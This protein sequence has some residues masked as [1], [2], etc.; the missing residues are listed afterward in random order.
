MA[1]NYAVSLTPVFFLL[2]LTFGIA[3]ENQCKFNCTSTPPTSYSN[4]SYSVNYCQPYPFGDDPNSYMH[5]VDKPDSLDVRFVDTYQCNMKHFLGLVISW[6]VPIAGMEFLKGFQIRV[7]PTSPDEITNRPIMCRDMLFSDNT[8]LTIRDMYTTFSLDCLNRVTPGNEYY[9][10][11]QSLPKPMPGLQ[12]DN[13]VFMKYQAPDCSSVPMVVDC[14][15]GASG[16]ILSDWLPPLMPQVVV[17]SRTVLV[18]FALAP[19]KY[20]VN[21]YTVNLFSKKLNKSVLQEIVSVAE[22]DKK[23]TA[24][25]ENVDI[26]EYEVRVFPCRDCIGAQSEI[27]DVEEWKAQYIHGNVQGKSRTVEVYFDMADGTYGS[28]VYNYTVQLV[29]NDYKKMDP[30]SQVVQKPPATFHNI[31]PGFYTAKVA[32]YNCT[33]CEWAT[34]SPLE[35]DVNCLALSDLPNGS[36][37]CTINGIETTNTTFNTECRFSCHQGYESAGSTQRTCRAN[38]YSTT[39]SGTDFTCT[40]VKCPVLNNPP[41]GN[42][43]CNKNGMNAMS[44]PIYN[45]V[46]TYKCHD[47]FVPGDRSDRTCLAN[48]TWS[49]RNFSCIAIYIPQQ[50]SQ[51]REIGKVAAGVIAGVLGEEEPLHL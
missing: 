37:N 11:V 13:T 42:I 33:Q 14:P 26:G 44:T 41:N 17:S 20:N 6:S 7:T 38:K 22:G 35:V 15:D 50:E 39:W 1:F 30:L 3:A 5:F 40:A 18:N 23:G 31:P 46:C 19:E 10:E 16:V 9:I 27:F 48:R 28:I 45:T 29:S 36:K 51:Q 12:K 21:E 43:T 8:V 49:G 32:K 2:F 24:Q 47:G 4:I 34:S 25:F